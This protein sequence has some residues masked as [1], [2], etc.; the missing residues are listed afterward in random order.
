MNFTEEQKIAYRK[1]IAPNASDE[2]WSFFIAECE[3]RALIPGVHVVFQLRK[4]PE[5]NAQLQRNV[6]TKGYAYNHDYRAA[7]DCRTFRQVPGLRQIQ[8][9]LWQRK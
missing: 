8:V 3:R 6:D 5:F 4:A 7:P 2:Q 9:V 1:T